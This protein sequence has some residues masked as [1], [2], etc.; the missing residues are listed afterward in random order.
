[1]F[2]LRRQVRHIETNIRGDV[3]KARMMDLNTAALNVFDNPSTN[4]DY[5][6]ALC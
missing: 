6:Y 3:D 5:F 1:M 4:G 2:A